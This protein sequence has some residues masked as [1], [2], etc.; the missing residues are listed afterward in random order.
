MTQKTKATKRQSRSSMNKGSVSEKTPASGCWINLFNPIVGELVGACGYTHAMIDME[1]S[2]VSL[3][4]TLTMIR[5]VQHSGAKSWVRAP[6]KNPAWVGRLMDM[7]ADGVMVPMVNT[8]EEAQAL[9]LA[10]CYAPKGT[11]GMAAGIVRATGYGVHTEEYMANHRKHFQLIIQIETAE[12]VAVAS[13]LASVEGI[14]A[15]F[16]GPYDLAGS[17]GNVGEPEHKETRA[18]IRHVQKAVKACGKPLATLTNPSRGARK[19]FSEGYDLVFSGS[20]VGM[21]RDVF[22]ADVARND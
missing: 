6:D 19:L 21:L 5:A 8:V 16:I 17:L 15:V 3:D 2:P 1:H 10:S 9:A 20:D 11:R 4:S 12:A 14:D 18:A 13:D 22:K 7:G